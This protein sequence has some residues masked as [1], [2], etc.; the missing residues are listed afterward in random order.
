MSLSRR[1]LLA[2]AAATPLLTRHARAAGS[3]VIRIGVMN[4]M[5]GPLSDD[6]G[7]GS[8][9][10]VQQAIDDL[11]NLGFQV[12]VLTADHQNKPDVG[13]TLARQWYDQADVD[14][15][16]DVPISSIAFGI[17]TLA[18]EKNKMFIASGSGS[19]DITGKQCSPNTIQW[20]YD[21]YMLAK[22][23]GTQ[24]VKSGGDKW[25]FIT[26]DYVFGHQLEHDTAHFVEAAGGKVLGTIAFPFPGNVDFSSYLLKAQASGANVLGVIANG[27]DLVNCVK[28]VSEFG[29]SK[30]LRVATPIVTINNI[31]ELGTTDA[32]GIFL[33]ETFYWDM[34]DRTRAFTKRVL[35]KIPGKHPPNMLQA[36]CYS[37]AMHYL[38][39]VAA[40]GVEKAKTDGRAVV[41]QMKR[42]RIDDD[43]F[44]AGSVRIDG[45]T[46]FPAYLFEVKSP[47]ESRTPW[48]CYKL[49][50]TTSPEDAWPP[51]G[52][53]CEFIHT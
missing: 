3:Q 38:K 26:A 1:S 21:T 5:T 29:L 15:I 24:V 2:A 28:Q 4:D 12:Q 27:Q 7:P 31:V 45:R 30:Q 39:A 33:T 14:L 40:L 51:L 23:I 46:L 10:C 47:A 37:G 22:S 32:K 16:I 42:T 20:T 13:V 52:R 35:P 17:S 43:A 44:G 50:A 49:K 9:A 6:G 53:G 11:G 36:G 34:N 18:R 19:T 25:F 48:D 41:E 8:A